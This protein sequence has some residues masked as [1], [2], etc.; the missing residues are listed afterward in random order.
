MKILITG[1]GGFVASAFVRAA[2]PHYKMRAL[3]RNTNVK[4]IE[5]RLT[6]NESAKRLIRA[7]RLEIVNGDLNGDISG[8]CEGVDF[9]LHAAAKTYVDNSIKD[10]YSFVE[11][12]ILGSF[13][14][15]EDARK[16]N[17][18]KFIMV[19]TDET[20]GEIMEGAYKEDA[21]CNPR[22]PYAFSKM[23]C[24][25]LAMCYAHT[26]GLNTVIT[27]M[28]NIYGILQHPQ[29][30]VPT[31]TKAANEDRKLPIYG[32]GDHVR[33]WLYLDD[34]VS[35]FQLLLE[36]ET[37]KGEIYH[38]A[39]NQELTNLDLAKKIL[40]CVNKPE[41]LISFIDDSII[42]PGH[43][44]RYALDSSK[45]RALGWAPKVS[46]DVGLAEATSW[47]SQNRWWSE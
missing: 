13:K 15:I 29:K 38:I 43:D 44:K 7:N 9:V 28:E 35:A 5:A 18:K 23:S 46:L 33:Q 36:A 41:S 37:K 26:Y 6:D 34:A 45:I 32:S 31:F 27:R 21:P 42:R 40:K 24:E 19:S 47:Y 39:G 17:V 16:H 14:L 4:R 25:G 12:N 11:S 3:V 10:P 30:V 2:L 20:L 8:I 22:N 1:A